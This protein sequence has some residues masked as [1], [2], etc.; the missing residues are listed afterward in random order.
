MRAYVC[1]LARQEPP[2]DKTLAN[3]TN[4]AFYFHIKKKKINKMSSPGHMK[5]NQQRQKNF[6][7]INDPFSHYEKSIL[8]PR[9]SGNVKGLVKFLIQY[10]G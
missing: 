4:S 1:V 6:K 9:V 3:I 7:K 8:K 10:K 2:E 5:L